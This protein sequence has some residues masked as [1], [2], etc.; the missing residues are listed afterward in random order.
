MA[1]EDTTT[2][3][4]KAIRKVL[5]DVF[6]TGDVIRFSVSYDENPTKYG[7]A[8]LYCGNR[9]W[10]VTGGANALGQGITTSQLMDKLVELD[11]KDAELATGWTSV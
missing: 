5:T 1:E 9:R 8:A 10:Y 11:I 4:L 7:Y 6:E 2:E 3:K